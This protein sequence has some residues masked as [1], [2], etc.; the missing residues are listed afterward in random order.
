MRESHAAPVPAQNSVEEGVDP[1]EPMFSESPALNGVDEPGIVS[2]VGSP[3]PCRTPPA[4]SPPLPDSKSIDNEEEEEEEE[5]EEMYK[6][7]AQTL[8]EDRISSRQW[9]RSLKASF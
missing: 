7:R 2:W 4:T 6:P 9:V 8:D 5:E 3:H 1:L